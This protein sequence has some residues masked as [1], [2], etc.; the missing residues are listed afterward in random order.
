[1]MRELRF[2]IR[3]LL[4][5][6]A[7]S[8][9]AAATLAL[10]IGATSAVFSLIQGVLLT[11]PP[12]RK[13]QQLMLVPSARTDGQ[14]MDSPRGWAAQQWMDWQKNTK[15]FDG[16]A[17]Y[18]WTFNFLIRNDGSQ[19]M[20]GMEVTKNYFQVMGIRPAVG[21]GFA[22]SDF[23]Q[24]PVKAVLLG[25][26]FWQKA[27]GGDPQIIG[28]TVRISRFDV[29]MPTVI[30]VMEP[31]VRFLPSPGAAKEPNYDVNATVDFWMPA[32]P[33]PKYL[34]EPYWNV[35]AR[36]Q[37]GVSLQRGQ[38]ELAVLTSEE[39]QT[40]KRFEGFT[41]QLEPVTQE[42]NRD[43]Q[44]ILLPLLG[45]AALV[46]LIACGNVA[47]L[48]LV[49][50]L[51]RQQEYAVRTAMGMGRLALLRQVLTESL[52][53]A[54]V[55]GAFG[56]VLAFG[57][58]KLFKVIAGH[59]VP[60]LESV[61]A[62]WAVLGW[63]LGAAVLAAFCA[64]ALPALRVF[65]LDPMEVLKSAG[66]KGTA[67]IGERRLLRG[68]TMLQ[69]AL[70]LALLVGAGLL[71]RTMM[72]I[73]QV[74]SGFN[75][76]RILTMSVT[77]VQGF[78]TWGSFHHQALERVA[79]I[80]GVQYAAFAWGVPLTGNNWPATLEIEGQP[81]AVKE[82]DKTALPL[83]AVTP[84]YFKLMGMPL[85]DGRDFR[86]SD[87][88]KA[89]G[90]AIVN[91]A[92]VHRY[93]PQGSAIGR[94]FWLNG[95]DKPGTEI[96]GE[97]ANG[98]TDDLTE[99]ASPEIYLPLWQASAFSKHLV[100]RTTADP[101]TAVVAVQRALRSVDPTAAIENVKTLG[102]I[103]DE[104][105]ASRTFAMHLLTA[106]SVVGSLLTLVGIYGVL[107]LSVAS[108]RREL[109]IRS[110]VGAQQSDIRRL[111]FGEGFRLI[112][113]GVVAGAALAIVLSRVLRSFLFEVQPSDPA[114][115]IVVGALFVA[116]GL[117]ACWLPVRR[118]TTVD[119]LEALRYD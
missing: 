11:P 19:S 102:Q 109:A 108:R 110:A 84:D 8:L 114:T 81:P 30:G 86:S 16:I 72:K 40:E 71:I 2:A 23:G 95:R 3:M 57:A 45:A 24:G 87:D 29:T 83:R 64:A 90:V 25:Y 50:G 70:T 106:F 42:M 48:L 99:E 17:A 67:G 116:V 100:V 34:K 14:K 15:S 32:I 80:P 36:L 89:P 55:G 33:D 62:G 79:A 31:G 98:R 21:R 52:L 22:D 26:E 111:I 82:S 20:Q 60:R 96:V 28:K 88:D 78:S 74:P 112:A 113:G 27:F 69:T 9:V 115:F 105:L 43:G 61:T 92:F 59:A 104:S 18:D 6:P 47:A 44:R 63:G 37:D 5:Q 12:Y 85:A 7:F 53:L 93:F 73:A 76:G 51:Q 77:D 107:T 49:R 4:K 41:P 54:V 65:Q 35:V 39:A 13:P 94:K 119:P 75:T 1:M 58:V 10:G 38:Q 103:R 91:Q 66:P 101:R 56:V 117:L 97:I 68:V 118:A 46:L